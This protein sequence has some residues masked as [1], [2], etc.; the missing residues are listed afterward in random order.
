MVFGQGLNGA[1]RDVAIYDKALSPEAIMVHTRAFSDS[2]IGGV[3]WP[4]AEACAAGE[5]LLEVMS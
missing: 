4:G 5:G 1:I 3:L 2:W